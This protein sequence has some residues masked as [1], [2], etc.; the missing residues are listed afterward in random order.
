ML[1]LSSLKLEALRGAT[2]AFEL[3]FEKGKTIVIVYGEN[4][5]GKSTVC[6]ALD[7]LGN[8]SLG[9]LDGKGLGSPARY[10]HSTNRK[11]SDIRVTLTA[12]A[13]TWTAQVAKSDVIVDPSEGCPR[14]AILR[15]HQILDLIA[16]RPA[17][18]YA[19]LRPF[20]AIDGIDDS[21]RTLRDLANSVG[22]Q[23]ALA[24]ARTGEN[25]ETIENVWK[26]AGSP[27][28]SMLAWAEM[29]AKRDTADLNRS[30]A[31]IQ[32]Y[33]R[34]R[35]DLDSRTK[36][37]ESS[38]TR[39]ESA[40]AALSLAELE[41][42][43]TLAE[44]ATG[45]EELTHLLEAASGF[46]KTHKHPE[47]CPLCESQE[48]AAKLPQTVETKLKAFSAVRA[49]LTKRESAH[50]TAEL[51]A[52]N[53]HTASTQAAKSAD[54]LSEACG[55]NWLS[56]L[57]SPKS[58]TEISAKGKKN[59]PN[60]QWPLEELKKL[61]NS[62][63]ILAELLERELT[64]RAQS[65]T[66]LKTIRDAL[67]QYKEN[68]RTRDELKALSPR[69]EDAHQVIIKERQEFVDEILEHI[70][71]RVGELYERVHPGEGLNKI[72]LQLD[73]KR[74]AS[75]DVVS[76]FPGTKDSP[77]AAYLSESHL[78]T[79]GLCI[80]LALSEQG[81]PE[82]TILVLDDVVASVDE[83][84]VD[85]IIGML[86]DISK[87]F[88]HCILTTH[89]Q[90][91]REKFRWGHLQTGECQFVELGS[92]TWAEG[93]VTSK[94]TPRVEVLR[95]HLA[96]AL[97]EPADVCAC[98]GVTL[99]AVLDFLTL[100]YE[101]SLPRR[102]TNLALR[103]L[104]QAIKKNL[105]ASLRV[106]MHDMPVGAGV[107]PPTV[108][109]G[110]VLD[111]LEKFAQARNIIGCHFNEMAFRLPGK[112]GLDF[113]RL[114]LELADAVIHPEDG[115]PVSDKSGEYWTN[116]GKSRRLYPL[117]QPS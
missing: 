83:P 69:L 79:L 63:A 62:A 44:A 43:A 93:I 100:Q 18:R 52:S 84:H 37:L 4:A 95:A 35:L 14:V 1:R 33:L 101:C 91:W 31:V 5:S 99:E 92:W 71:T 104:L 12:N 90:P 8:H 111:K 89:Y 26:Q 27:A 67:E 78:D 59:G 98:A 81:S 23:L 110:P 114:V 82:E 58:I 32:S 25:L 3:K 30:I 102:R 107:T 66:L 96:E 113:G 105:R 72:S 20:I 117:R 61:S 39:V 42:N 28:P 56:D 60:G 11:P 68:V 34:L 9:S 45:S 19:A 46:F 109:L 24:E 48:F 94:S 54:S 17:D 108:M 53:S 73:P 88:A 76:Q 15:R 97:P 65:V 10:W 75:L 47:S 13:G 21:E 22:R 50:R 2:Q 49:A 74:R 77:P 64:T 106:E 7:L 103:E 40:N 86:Y 51:A 80:F 57:P 38:A 55:K 29:E 16:G 87:G 116:S 70:A 85:R 41:L 115:W 112:D 6:D 36:D